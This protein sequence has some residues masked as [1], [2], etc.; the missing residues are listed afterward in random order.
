M[1]TH[2][3]FTDEHELTRW[4]LEN[5]DLKAGV[6]LEVIRYGREMY[7]VVI[8]CMANTFAKRAVSF[9]LNTIAMTD[10]EIES[11]LKRTIEMMKPHFVDHDFLRDEDPN[12]AL[13]EDLAGWGVPDELL[14]KVQ[15]LI[16]PKI[17][18]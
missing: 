4:F 3:R 1:A 17:E 15:N 12:I 8:F 11:E 2:N 9:G 13:I 10:D 5:I 16:E 7:F 6:E 14:Q 18:A